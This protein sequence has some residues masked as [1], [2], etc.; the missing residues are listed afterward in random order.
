MARKTE[1]IDVVIFIASAVVAI[2]GLA[3]AIW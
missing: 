1:P 3:L 2:T